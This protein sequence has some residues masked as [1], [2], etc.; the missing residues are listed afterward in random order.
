MYRKLLVIGQNFFPKNHWPSLIICI[1]L[2]VFFNE[3]EE[4]ADIFFLKNKYQIK[5]NR[6]IF[7]EVMRL[8]YIITSTY[9]VHRPI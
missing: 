2:F 4:G 9:T 5:K 7:Y 3:G 1:D 6:K 8:D